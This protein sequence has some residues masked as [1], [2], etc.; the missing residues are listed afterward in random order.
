MCPLYVIYYMQYKPLFIYS[1]CTYIQVQWAQPKNLLSFHSW[2]TVELFHYYT[3]LKTFI[4]SNKSIVR[5]KRELDYKN[6]I[7]LLQ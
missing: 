4:F 5:M 2:V 1:E 7:S 3:L 6:G